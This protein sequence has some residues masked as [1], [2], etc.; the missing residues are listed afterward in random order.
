MALIWDATASEVAL[1][2][3][4]GFAGGAFGASI[5]AL[6][7]FVVTGIFTIA[8]EAANAFPASQEGVLAVAAAPE[9]ASGITYGLAFGPVFGP[10]VSFAGGAAAAA[11]A[12]KHG[13]MPEPSDGDYHPAKDIAYALGTRVD[14]LAVGGAFGMLGVAIRRT[15]QFT[16]T[17]P[18]DPPAM[19]VIGSAVVARLVFGYPMVGSV[20]GSSLFDMG[21][22]ESGQKRT[23]T[24]GGTATDGPSNYRLAVEPWLPHQ[25]EW[26]NVAMIG[27]VAGIAGA[28][29]GITTNSAVLAFGL[30]A[31]SLLFLNL[32]VEKFPVTHHITL[33]AAFVA[34][35]VTTPAGETS[36]ALAG[37]SGPVALLLGGAAGIVGALLGEVVQ[38]VFYA[39]SDTHFD[40]PAGSIILTT[41]TLGVLALLGVLPGIGNIPG[42]L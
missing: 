23:A 41:L 30:S 34:V 7:A 13:G 6:P 8:G 36:A 4:A 33:P 25:Y 18:I 16:L 32:G 37:L 39:H 42:T 24:D 21:P 3:I 14:V 27:L 9:A 35:M 40:P 2:L 22:F 5:G 38:R 17:L 10:H 19:G 20:R 26:G 29:V 11:Y 28:F 1:L 12:A 15:S 31:A